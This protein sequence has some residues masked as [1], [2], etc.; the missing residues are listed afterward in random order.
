VTDPEY[1]IMR[2]PGQ[3]DEEFVLI[4]P[5]TPTTKQNMIAWIAARSD[6]D[7]YGQLLVFKFPKQTLLYG[8]EQI[9]A[10]INQDPEIVRQ[11]T[12]W[13]SANQGDLMVIPIGNSIVY[14]RP[15]YLESATNK[16]PELKRVIVSYGDR[17]VMEPSLGEAFA[18]IFGTPV[19]PGTKPGPTTGTG[20]TQAGQLSAAVQSLITQANDLYRRAQEAITAGDWAAYGKA[21]QDLGD[22]LRRLQDATR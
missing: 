22:V 14:V 10:R 9:K 1:I 17:V 8:P 2:L 5:Y 19:S 4:M 18:R 12:L 7:H 11:L 6:G 3:T 15:L 16:L 13:T 20:G 21:V